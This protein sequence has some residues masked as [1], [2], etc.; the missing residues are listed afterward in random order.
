MH[1]TTHTGLQLHLQ[2]V[3]FLACES[4]KCRKVPI[5]LMG[6]GGWR[7]GEGKEREV[8]GPIFTH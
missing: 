7:E 8:K 3:P 6:V 2:I 1:V 5:F 4:R